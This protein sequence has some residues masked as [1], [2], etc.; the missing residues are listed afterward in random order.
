M[1]EDISLAV[2]KLR[3]K[4]R[5]VNAFHRTFNTADGK[6]AMEILRAAFKTDAP[7]FL[8]IAGKDQ[9]VRFDPI[10]AAIRSGQRDVILQ[11][12]AYLKIPIDGDANIT[13]S[14][15]EKKVRTE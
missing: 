2:Q 7:A 6:Y 5:K 15:A 12:E 8:N 10:H 13:P 4:Q 11:I 3:L 9:G 14:K 1:S